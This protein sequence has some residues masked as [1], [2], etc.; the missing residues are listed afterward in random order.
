MIGY[1]F[2]DPY[3][4]N[5]LFNA[6]KNEKKLII[7]NPY[8]GPEKI[9]SGNGSI[10][11]DTDDFYRIRYPESTNRSDLTDYLREIQRNSFYSELPEFNYVY[12]SAENVE[13]IP[14]KAEEFIKYFLVIMVHCCANWFGNLKKR[15]KKANHFSLEYFSSYI[16][17]T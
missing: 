17:P 6:V 1:S 14:L 8:F 16:C 7:V 4:N 9:Y 2:F 5:L 12:V 11:N 15:K 3:I 10:A 13:F